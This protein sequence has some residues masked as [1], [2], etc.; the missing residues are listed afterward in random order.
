M[1]NY[2]PCI[3]CYGPSD[4]RTSDGYPICDDCDTTPHGNG[5]REAFEQFDSFTAGES[6]IC[7]AFDS[8]AEWCESVAA[9]E[10][11]DGMTTEH[12]SETHPDYSPDDVAEYVAA[13]LAACDECAAGYR[14]VGDYDTNGGE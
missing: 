7:E 14:Y 10:T 1:N 6:S 5:R 8:W 9:Y 11:S 4:H 12:V 2:L 3:S 13:Y